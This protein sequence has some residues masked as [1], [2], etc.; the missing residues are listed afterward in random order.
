MRSF[1]AVLALVA[2]ADAGLDDGQRRR[3][4][5]AAVHPADQADPLERGQVAAHGLGR[6]VELLGELEHREPAAAG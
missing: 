6:D 4:D 1:S 2:L 3:R 5:G